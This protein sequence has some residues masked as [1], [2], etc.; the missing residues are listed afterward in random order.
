MALEWT[1]AAWF[2]PFILPIAIWVSWSD[3]AHMKIPNKAVIAMLAV[4][5]LVG[6][7]ALPFEEYLWRYAHIACC[8]R[9]RLCDEFARH[10]GRRRCQI[11]AGRRTVH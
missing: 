4:F 10:D 8:V 7:V 1:T 2:L 3:L 6:L 11:R 5:A 9:D